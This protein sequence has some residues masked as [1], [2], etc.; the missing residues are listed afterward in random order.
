[1]R[2][3]YIDRADTRIRSTHHK[4]G[5]D[6]SE[7]VYQGI[8][9]RLMNSQFATKAGSG[10]FVLDSQDPAGTSFDLE[11]PFFLSHDVNGR[12]TA[13]D[14][15]GQGYEIPHQRLEVPNQRG[16]TAFASSFPHHTNSLPN[17]VTMTT[18]TD[19][20]TSTSTTFAFEE[21]TIY[22]RL[23]ELEKVS[24]FHRAKGCPFRVT[25]YASQSDAETLLNYQEGR[26]GAVT[27]EETIKSYLNEGTKLLDWPRRDNNQTLDEAKQNTGYS[28]WRETVP[29]T[30]ENILRAHN[31][32]TKEGEGGLQISFVPDHITLE[33]I[34]ANL[35]FVW[36]HDIKQSLSPT[37]ARRT[38]KPTRKEPSFPVFRGTIT[39]TVPGGFTGSFEITP[40]MSTSTFSGRQ[41]TDSPN[42]EARNAENRFTDVTDLEPDS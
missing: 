34:K 30:M 8:P 36:T 24:E 14:T 33:D 20:Q 7:A 38:V 18:P 25:T 10:T 19:T 32:N 9:E 2:S 13:H 21:G 1:M 4:A 12:Y 5:Q 39:S 15:T 42:S 16:Q 31:D 28:E 29:E 23:N 41:A 22:L 35:S 40:L 11:H 17:F 6:S 3:V 37:T 26:S 27:I